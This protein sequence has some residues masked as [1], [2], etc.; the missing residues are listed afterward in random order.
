MNL[1]KSFAATMAGLALSVV[2]SHA[3]LTLN[4]SSSPGGSVIQFNGTN[5]SFQ[6]NP[7]TTPLIIPNPPSPPL[8]ITYYVGSQWSITSVVGGTGSALSLLGSVTNGPFNYGPITT[9]IVGSHI[10]ETADVTGPLGGLSISDN[11]GNFLT[12]NVDWVQ[13]A[14]HDFGGSI[15][16]GLTVNVTDLTY[17]GTNPDLEAL[18]ASGNGAMDLTFQFAPGMTLTDLTTGSGAYQTSYS[19][20]L[21]V[22]PEPTTVGCF[23]LGLGVLTLTRRFR[24]NKRG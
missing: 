11:A 24:Q 15:N 13:L 18:V 4:F 3:Q 22:V 5:S 17:A 16:A 14:T 1:I 2:A 19:G 9:T 10:D 20:S 21:S 6:F 7:S 23:L 12:G 8:T